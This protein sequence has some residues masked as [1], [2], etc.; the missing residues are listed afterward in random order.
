LERRK[1]RSV[2][3]E[4]VDTEHVTPAYP[5]RTYFVGTVPSSDFVSFDVYAT[6]DD[7]VDTIPVRVS[8]LVDG[9]PQSHVVRLAADT[10]ATNSTVP[11]TS[12]GSSLLPIA[13]GVVV[14]LAVFGIIAVG[15]KNS[16]A[17]D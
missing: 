5:G 9:T 7:T 13:V 1:H 15:W 3:V 8:Y 12:R 4:A 11:K 17:S 2:V 6:T 16:R 14:S 10:A